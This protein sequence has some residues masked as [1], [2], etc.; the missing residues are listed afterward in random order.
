VIFVVSFFLFPSPLVFFRC[1]RSSRLSILIGRINEFGVRRDVVFFSFF[2]ILSLF[3]C[4]FFLKILIFFP[5][6]V[7]SFMARKKPVLLPL[8]LLFL[9]LCNNVSYQLHCLL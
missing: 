9:V 8:R 4:F 1:V 7:L 2:F 5:S 6:S 3:S